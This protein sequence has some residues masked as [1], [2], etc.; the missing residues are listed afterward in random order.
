[1]TPVDGAPNSPALVP[2]LEECLMVRGVGWSREKSFSWY[3]GVEQD[4]TVEGVKEG[5]LVR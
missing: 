1:M 5:G 3:G 2:V 4:R